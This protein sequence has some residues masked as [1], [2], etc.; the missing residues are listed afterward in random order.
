MSRVTVTSTV[1]PS[2]T[3][4]V[5]ASK[6]AVTAGSSSSVM[7]TVEVVVVPTLTPSGRAAEPQDYALTVVVWSSS[8]AVE[9]ER[10]GPS[11]S[12]PKVTRSTAE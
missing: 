12:G 3:V 11:P 8:V 4:Y 5:D 9:G 2:S 6:L 10:P 7:E 1:L